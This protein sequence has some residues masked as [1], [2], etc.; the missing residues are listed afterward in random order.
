MGNAAKKNEN[1]TR[2]IEQ[3]TGMDFHGF[4]SVKKNVKNCVDQPR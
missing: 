3:K 1:G 2:D 4:G